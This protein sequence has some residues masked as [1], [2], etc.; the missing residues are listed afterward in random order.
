[1]AAIWAS[2]DE[3]ISLVPP[4]AAINQN[5]SVRG[6][7]LDEESIGTPAA[8]KRIATIYTNESVVPTTANEGVYSCASI[9]H[10]ITIASND[11]VVGS[12]A[13]E[14]TR[15]SKSQYPIV[16]VV[17]SHIEAEVPVAISDYL[18]IVRNIDG[19][20]WR[21]RCSA[22]LFSLALGSNLL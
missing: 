5:C 8:I 6:S 14:L 4:E 12:T 19:C 16:I 22:V 3:S 13:V 7:V 2:K 11:S 9:Q 15:R 17:G 10:I 20:K 21:R 18:D 1:M